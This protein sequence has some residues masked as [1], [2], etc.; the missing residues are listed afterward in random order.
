[1]P[2]QVSRRFARAIPRL[3]YPVAT[4]LVLALVPAALRSQDRTPRDTSTPPFIRSAADSLHPLLRA[5]PG[6]LPV[7]APGRTAADR[8]GTGPL[9]R[10]PARAVAAARDTASAR[11]RGDSL[12]IAL[13]ARLETRTERTKAHRCV[14][15][16]IT[17]YAAT[18]RSPFQPNMDFQFNLRSGG[19][20]AER[21]RVDVDYDSQRE[22]DASNNI[23]LRYSGK[24]G[25]MLRRVEVGNV[26]FTPPA[27]RF[28]TG[29]IPTG[30]YGVQ[31]EGA[32]GRLEFRSIV[33]RQTG[34]VVKDRVFTIGERAMQRVEREVE[35]HQVEARRFFFVVDPR[36][37]PGYPNIDIL[38]AARMRAL[39]ASL[40]DSIRPARVRLYRLLLGGQPPV[41]G[42]PR[43]RLIGDPTSRPA[44]AYEPLREQQD[45]YVDPS[46]LWVALARPLALG[47]ERLVA[48]YTVRIA[49]RETVV[50]LGGGTPDLEFTSAHEQLAHLLW[51][52]RVEARDAAFYRE[53]RSVYRI[54]GEDIRRETIGARIVTGASADLERP[55]SGPFS[56]Y[57]EMFGLADRTA[58]ARLDVEGRV[59][60][61]TGDPILTAGGDPGA[62]GRIVH[63]L[64]LVFPSLAP[65]ARDGLVAP[66]NPTSDSLYRSPAEY[67]YSSRHPPSAYRMRIAY[68]S[69]ATAGGATNTLALGSI[70]V[71]PGSERL[72]LD[73]VPLVRGVDYLV[74]Y[75]LGIVTFQRPDTLFVGPRRVTARYEE[76]PL[77]VTTPTSILGVTTRLPLRGGE[78]G[79]TAISQ[80]QR[81]SFTRPT[82][83]Y[84]PASSVVA[85]VHGDVAWEVAPLQRMLARLPSADPARPARLRIQGELAASAPRFAANQQAYLESFEGDGGFAVPL[86]EGAWYLSSR[87]ASSAALTSRAGAG[88]LSLQRATTLA[89]Q[90]AGL[91]ADGRPVTY[92]IE[93]MDPRSVVVGSGFSGEQILWLTLYPLGIAEAG[94]TRWTVPGAPV[95]RRW[96]SVRAPLGTQ[97][98]D[99]TR[100][101]QLEFWTAVDTSASRR[102]RNP[103]LVVDVGEVSENTVAFAPDTLVVTGADSSLRGKRIVHLDTLDSER[104]SLSRAFNAD[105][106]D[107]GLPGDVVPRLTVISTAGTEVRLGAP[108]C[109][110]AAAVPPL[111]GTAA[112]C[113]VANDRLDEE[114]L[115]GDG[116][117]N[118]TD[119]QRDRE[120]L[121]RFVVDLSDPAA[122]ARVGRCNVG[123]G[124][125]PDATIAGGGGAPAAPDSAT[126]CWVLVR[127]PFA[128]PQELLNAP[129]LRRARSIRLTMISGAGTEDDRFTTLP[130]ARLRFLGAPW[131]RRNDRPLR[132][133]AGDVPSSGFVAASVVGTQD[134]DTLGLNYQ[135]PPG[136]T[137]EPDVRRTGLEASRIQINERSLRLLA[138]GLQPLDRAEAFYRF[139]EGQKNFLSYR[140]LR[141]WARGRGHGW[142]T[143][144]EMQFYVKIGRDENNF[145]LYRTPVNAGAGAAAW[146]PEVRVHLARFQALRARLQESLVDGRTQVG[147]GTVDSLLVARAGLPVGRPFSKYAA[148]DAGYLVYSIDPLA[149]APNLAAVQE[150]SVG[151]VRVDVG[152]PPRPASDTLELWVDDIRLGGV[153]ADAGMAGTIGATL[154]AGDLGDLRVNL[155]RRDP[156]F[157]QLAES[158]SFLDDA[159]LD[160]GSTVR[161]DRLLPRGAGLA[162]PLTFS[163]TTTTTDPYFVSRSD[164]R[165]G[166][167][168]GLRT[169]RSSESSV[170]LSVRRAA[171]G[172]EDATLVQSFLDHLAATATFDRLAQRSEY[173]DGSSHRLTIGIEYVDAPSESRAW[174]GVRLFSTVVRGNEQRRS[175][176]LPSINGRGGTP[177]RAPERLWRSGGS[178]ELRPLPYASVRWNGTSVRDLRR[179]GAGAPVLDRERDVVLGLNAGLERERLMQGTASFTPRIRPWLR[180]MFEASSSYGVVRDPASRTLVSTDSSVPVLQGDSLFDP[181]SPALRLP[182]RLT[183]SRQGIAGLGLEPVHFVHPADSGF[184][185]RLWRA[186][187]PLE[188]SVT[189][190]QLTA[191]DGTASAAPL[192]VQLGLGGS[193]AYRAIAGRDASAASDATTVSL[194]GGVA[195]PLGFAL[196]N[197]ATVLGGTTWT[198]RLA[199]P[200]GQVLTRQ[201][202]TP[203]FAARWVLRGAAGPLLS[204][205][206]SARAMRTRQLV[207][208]LAGSGGC[209]ACPAADLRTS[210][211]WR[212]PIQV[213][214]QWAV[215]HG[216]TTS[217]GLTHA[218]RVDSLPGSVLN[219]R[220]REVSADIA[221][222]FPA[223][224]RWGLRGDIRSRLAWQESA[225]ESDA[226]VSGSGVAPSR[227][228][229]NGRR[230]VTFSADAEV[231]EN[232][233]FTLQGSHVLNFD[234]N[235]NR[236]VTQ[237]VLSAVLQIGFFSGTVR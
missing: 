86:N 33:A 69:D 110:R 168:P 196:S 136:V 30:N 92:S 64:F 76:N 98:A 225:G 71:R 44:E 227:L 103:L 187:Q 202:T 18:C 135:S 89:W 2:E 9:A 21:V 127:L 120:R 142:G 28:I 148:C 138:G 223:P 233:T 93:R 81:S 109:R 231:V 29:G 49:G 99:L 34:N 108:L 162:M 177:V 25:E 66:G 134:R 26:S 174:P 180:G 208:S 151:M 20:V 150:M 106:N 191:F 41:P 141:V 56:T 139:P 74:D 85:G 128:Q 96:R 185:A 197:R 173:Q 189:R 13:N 104:D 35:D 107:T 229:D 153:V 155:L 43:F 181:A 57:L 79:F 118:L 119:A 60:P 201:R 156:R 144:G 206:A 186:V 215:P 169:P 158:P 73:G 27:S 15:Q 195:L 207:S 37:L 204:G 84:E 114:D 10:Q 36:Q 32:F 6:M 59:W 228:T 200:P 137:D 53:I 102:A 63:D 234:R 94:G 124:G 4:V 55:E 149:T 171:P 221:R 77:F 188:L 52:P 160:V 130:V 152:G 131:V 1:M 218:R 3:P 213:S 133:I 132:G 224:A 54:G 46:G 111:G 210:R 12:G 236:R 70:Q 14:A 193:G 113:T 212:Y 179:F 50:P 230:A 163:H 226:I 145:Y 216:L 58:P 199:G 95:G 219:S 82:L 39:A 123:F 166:A 68:Q 65:F 165:G 203:D 97:G 90:N 211:T 17:L 125:A 40:P 88:T 61:R 112:N 72:L 237:T 198:A 205:S 8:L 78:I 48:A 24:P 140:E 175:F 209:A 157:R 184:A 146:L 87:P 116:I 121:A 143:A 91:G 47:R 5:T 192:L 222:A 11:P 105:R 16:Q 159:A 19:T 42:G 183:G 190:T 235:L 117:L 23:S 164:L 161:L 182:R 51:D 217:A 129:S 31:A 115:D 101:E 80:S 154:T 194:G 170:A 100:V 220:G 75:D 167:V 38:D 176:L 232:V 45:Y 214:L 67:L 147:C 22:F 62:A 126:R 172:R 83:G 122:V 178:F 7:T